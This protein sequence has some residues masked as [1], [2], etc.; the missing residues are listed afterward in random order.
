MKRIKPAA[1]L[2]LSFGLGSGMVA[3]AQPASAM[4]TGMVCPNGVCNLRS[5]VDI[6]C[7]FSEGWQCAFSQGGDVCTSTHC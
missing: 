1:I 2:L 3:L 4:S 7:V 5:P 6:D